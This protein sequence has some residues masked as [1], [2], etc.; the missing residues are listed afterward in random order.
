MRESFSVVSSDL[1]L[2]LKRLVFDCPIRVNIPL[3][4]VY[5]LVH[6][7]GV[8]PNDK[9]FLKVVFSEEFEKCAFGVGF[10]GAEGG[11][12]AVNG[13]VCFVVVVDCAE[14]AAG[15]EMVFQFGEAFGVG[16]SG[17]V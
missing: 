1:V 13:E 16:D 14:G 10:L 7:V 8:R 5:H 3:P 9:R 11:V 15:S 4:D 6:P 12:S 17:F 2:V